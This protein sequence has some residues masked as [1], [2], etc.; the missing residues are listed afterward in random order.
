MLKV[1]V[2][3]T[4]YNHEKYIR[5][6]LEGIFKQK[7]N[8]D[9]NVII[10]DDASTDD[11]QK[12]I[13]EFEIKYPKIVNAIYQKK[14]LHSSGIRRRQFVEA[15]F[16]GDY[17]AFCEGDDYWTD[18]KKLQ[19]QV[20]F[21]DENFDYSFCG[22]SYEV[23]S[24]LNQKFY[25]GVVCDN[26]SFDLL[27][28]LKKDANAHKEPNKFYMRPLSIMIRTDVLLKQYSG[29][30]YALHITALKQGKGKC[31]KDKMGVYR[32][33]ESSMTNNKPMAFNQKRIEWRISA[34]NQVSKEYHNLIDCA[35]YHINER[36]RYYEIAEHL[37]T[38]QSI[39]ELN[40]FLAKNRI[41]KVAVYGMGAVGN[42]LIKNL[43]KTNVLLM[44]VI[45]KNLSTDKKNKV[46]AFSDLEKD[47][48]ADVIIVT[49]TFN[50]EETKQELRNLGIK[51]K[52]VS[53][54]DVL[55]I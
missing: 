46:I 32:L 10:H 5:D 17:I 34:K 45:D 50:Y 22:H 28:F 4:T 30:D 38:S 24:E 13:R 2:L 29:G 44:N 6:T 19:K 3:V 1:S 55:S 53:I 27:D 54:E 16:E 23:Y 49:I 14:N 18:E 31:I 8:F 51:N 36:N 43:Q 48:E 37:K 42:L 41:E 25:G 39:D 15:F 52:I 35:I 47:F 33:H 20:D 21:L 12:I 26:E 9:F 7:T 11:T 40:F